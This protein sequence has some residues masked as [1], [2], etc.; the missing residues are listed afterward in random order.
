MPFPRAIAR[1]GALSTV[2]AFAT[3]APASVES[4]QAL[5][6]FN[7]LPGEFT[8][9]PH[10]GW[11]AVQSFGWG[12]SRPSG[13]FTSASFPQFSN[14]SLARNADALLIGL[15][16][17]LANGTSIDPVEIEFYDPELAYAPITLKLRDARIL[18]LSLSG[19]DGEP[20]TSQTTSVGFSRFELNLRENPTLPNLV[21]QAVWN[22]QT[23]IGGVNLP[24]VLT[25][26]GSVSAAE[27]TTVPL[28][29]TV[30]D[31]ISP[32]ETLVLSAVCSNPDLIPADGLVLSG[33]GSSRTLTLTPALDAYGSAT[34]SLTAVDEYGLSSARQIQVE[35]QAVNDAPAL[36][37][38]NPFFLAVG[39]PTVIPV[40]LE[41]V[42]TPATN[43]TLQ[44][45]SSDPSLVPPSAI[46]ISGTGASRLVT[47]TPAQSGSV[48]LTFS[49]GDGEFTQ[50][51]NLEVPIAGS[52]ISPGPY[53]FEPTNL[54]LPEN[55][56]PSQAIA[57]IQV[58]DA[59]QAS[60]HDLTLIDD[61]GGAFAL[62]GN[63]LSVANPS[64]F[65]FE[66]NPV[67]TAT[68]RA[69]NANGDSYTGSLSVLV[70]NVNEAPVVLLGPAGPAVPFSPNPLTAISIT[71]PDAGNSPVRLEVGVLHG[72]LTL[73]SAGVS[74]N[75]TANLS[76]EAP[77]PQLLEAIASGQ[78]TYSSNPAY[79]GLD[80]LRVYCND[81]GAT[82]AGTAA[83]DEALMPFEVLA[84]PY[85]LWRAQHFTVEERAN[86]FLSGDA[87]DFDGDGLPNLVEYVLGTLPKDS[88]SGRN[89]VR[90]FVVQEG[91][92]EYPAVEFTR[93]I[94]T[95]AFAA[96]VEVSRNLQ[97][98]DSTDVSLL[99]LGVAYP[100]D[101]TEMRTVRS[102]FPLST[103]RTQQFRIRVVRN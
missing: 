92:Q 29:F 78:L 14:V 17:A 66:T 19:A 88:S 72:T 9:P 53:G 34:I 103:D 3:H 87:V 52:G 4:T 12:V 101:S 62:T 59:T 10:A 85:E 95:E 41:D 77:L 11:S 94:Q 58:L 39:I 81:L 43:L 15:F 65:D 91:G 90:V 7:G 89:R 50:D 23:N 76:V 8:L 36:S 16:A 70:T 61:A 26:P 20:D 84:D 31:A 69:E 45:L 68:L 82:G 97:S 46:Q 102:R 55:P 67:L 40:N 48:L 86:P 79:E 27:D 57:T 96:F 25:T 24:P 33:T 18:S 51:L 54:S 93:S 60:G 63:L 32:L 44:V 6:R 30:G 21:R 71:D 74:G 75:G 35:I 13:A 99:E 64:R 2:L 1:L 28:V 22:L 49:V 100:T 47:L 80:V 38:P 37:I 5:V 56:A 42:D 73:A 83:A 98:W